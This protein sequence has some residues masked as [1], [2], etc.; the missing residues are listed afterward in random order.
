MREAGIVDR[1]P[2]FADYYVRFIGHFVSVYERSA[3]MFARDSFRWSASQA[4]IDAYHKAGNLMRD[5]IGVPLRAAVNDLLPGEN[6]DAN[7][8]YEY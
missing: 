3:T 6:S 5:V 8:P 2:G 1:S 4:N 7:W